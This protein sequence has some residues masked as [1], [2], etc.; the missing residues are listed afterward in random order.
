MMEPATRQDLRDAITDLKLYVVER[1]VTAIRW[2]VGIQVTY[3]TI[4]IGV[5][6]FMLQHAH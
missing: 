2:F 6:Y 1:E 3:T 4:I 5:M